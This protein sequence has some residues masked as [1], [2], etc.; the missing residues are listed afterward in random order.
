M[1]NACDTQKEACSTGA[2]GH[3]AEAENCDMHEKLLCLADQAWKEV[4]KEKIKAEIEKTSG[5]K[6]NNIAKLVAETNH[7]RWSH[8]IEGKQKCEEFKQQLREIMVSN[9]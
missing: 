5:Q 4:L 7:R 3:K 8:M 9:K 6:L 2:A 1:D